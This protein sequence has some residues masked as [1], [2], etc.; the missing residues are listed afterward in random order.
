MKI[1]NKE[2]AKRMSDKAIVI[3]FEGG[4]YVQR[5]VL[6]TASEDPLSDKER[7]II[8]LFNLLQNNQLRFHP[9]TFERVKYEE[10]EPYIETEHG[11]YFLEPEQYNNALTLDQLVERCKEMRELINEK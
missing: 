3:P 6:M 4:A 2:E 10:G 1:D 5:T 7:V 8:H 11:A 9:E